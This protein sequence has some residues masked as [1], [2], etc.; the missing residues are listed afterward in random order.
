MKRKKL[1]LKIAAHTRLHVNP[2]FVTNG[3][4]A[5]KPALF[6][7][8]QLELTPS[9]TT[10]SYDVNGHG[11]LS[12][13]FG[14]SLTPENVQR[15]FDLADG[16]EYENVDVRW[17]DGVLIKLV[18]KTVDAYVSQQ[19]AP[20]IERLED[21]GGQWQINSEPENLKALRFV[22]NGKT[23]ALLMPCKKPST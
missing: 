2:Y 11:T 20:L 23:E 4:F 3:V 12:E 5:I 15:V 19:C 14:S 18:G 17:P 7:E 6:D 22:L 10:H 1:S 9:A 21:L 8:F 16:C 13:P